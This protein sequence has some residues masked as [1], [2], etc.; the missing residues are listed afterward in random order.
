M[1]V[2]NLYRNNSGPRNFF[3]TALHA[4]SSMLLSSLQQH[5]STCT[6]FSDAIVVTTAAQLYMHEVLRCYCRHDSSTALHGR[7][8]PMLFSSLQQQSSTCSKFSDAIVVATALHVRSFRCYCRHYSSICKK[9]S[10][11]IVVTTALH[12]NSPMLLAS[13]RLH[14]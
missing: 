1:Y 12:V 13:L 11:A 7:S 14:M 10:D 5:S 2:R 3:T 8:S 4:S 6:K 9:F